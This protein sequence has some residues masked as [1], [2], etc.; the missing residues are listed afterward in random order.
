MA[1]SSCSSKNKELLAQKKEQ[2]KQ[3][4]INEAVKNS[5]KMTE[6]L[7]KELK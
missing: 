6:E 2:L 7:N 3:Q 5:D 4:R 1:F